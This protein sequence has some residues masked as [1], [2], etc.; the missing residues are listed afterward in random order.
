MTGV[1]AFSVHPGGIISG[2]NAAQI[3]KGLVSADKFPDS[4]EAAASMIGELAGGHYDALSG[5]YLDV[6]DNLVDLVAQRANQSAPVRM[7]I[8]ADLPDE[9]HA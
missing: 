3:K 6:G 4:V 9:F 5:S 8:V 1:V 7:L 2:I